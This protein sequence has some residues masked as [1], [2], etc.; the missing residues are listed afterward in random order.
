MAQLHNKSYVSLPSKYL[1]FTF[2]FLNAKHFN[3]NIK[4]FIAFCLSWWQAERSF[5]ISDRNKG[6]KIRQIAVWSYNTKQCYGFAKM[7]ID[8]PQ[9]TKLLIEDVVA[10]GSVDDD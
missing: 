10:L 7:N 6:L 2:L 4:F 8:F 1:I 5:F 3:H 9:A